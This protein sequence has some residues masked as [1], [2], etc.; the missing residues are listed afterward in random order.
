M[1]NSISRFLRRM[2][3]WMK[4]L[5]LIVILF[6]GILFAFSYTIDRNYYKEILIQEIE[7]EIQ[8]EFT[9]EK[10]NLLIFPS[11]GIEIINISI[12]NQD[13]LKAKAYSAKFY[14]SIFELFLKRL[15]FDE[16]VISNL[17][18][19]YF[20]KRIELKKKKHE[21]LQK[22]VGSI[23]PERAS[24]VLGILPK[25][26]K[27]KNAKISYEDENYNLKKSFYVWEMLLKTS[28]A[29]RKAHLEIIG[30]VDEKELSYF[31]DASFERDEFTFESFRLN[32]KINFEDLPLN[33]LQEILVIFPN[34]DFSKT[35][36]SIDGTIYK[37]S[38]LAIESNLKARANYFQLKGK[39]PMSE[40]E[41][42]SII[43]FHI[44]EKKLYFKDISLKQSDQ[45]F[46][47]GLG[48]VTFTDS[49]QIYFKVNGQYA[50][51]NSLI[52]HI[53]VWWD[54]DL[55]RS[56]LLIDIP[57]TGYQ[58]RMTI[59]LDLDI[60]NL[61]LEN[62]KI[63]FFSLNCKYHYP[64]LEVIDS[65]IQVFGGNVFSTAIL[66]VNQVP[67]FEINS[68][69][70]NLNVEKTINRFTKDKYLTGRLQGDFQTQSFGKTQ[71]EILKNLKIKSSL[72][73]QDGELLGYANLLIPIAS[74]GKLINFTGPPGKSL[75]FSKINATVDYRE[76]SF[77]FSNI[78]LTGVG[79]SGSGKGKISLDKKISMDFQVGLP[80]LAG[81]IIK[82]PIL[83]RGYFGKNFAIVDPVW[84]GSVYAGTILLG[85]A[86][87]TAVGMIAGSAASDYVTKAIE[88]TEKVF[89]RIGSWFGRKKPKEEEE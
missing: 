48:H 18:L 14:V 83:Y 17:E 62:D 52:D 8:M 28:P 23:P 34:S 74:L 46:L 60:Q 21:E 68:K 2:P 32:S 73:V 53:L 71:E 54:A 39:A 87:G 85:G 11:P 16:I 27:L 41:A 5:S 55:D 88:S 26:T 35:I 47:S 22:E 51:F 29:R 86:H 84:I 59:R 89:Q 45:N 65:K 44:S 33:T 70:E 79:L 50:N 38:D 58:Y 4:V 9:F 61:R 43:G 31:A 7:K 10:T 36:L 12:N 76:R 49:P 40:V 69:V 63:N 19:L 20:R 13:Q 78:Q 64:Q 72:S 1:K 77:F 75:S 24:N 82:I 25:V 6:F 67:K 37:D 42:Q 3:T 81:K 57:D 66:S 30:K 15:S 56:P 80:G